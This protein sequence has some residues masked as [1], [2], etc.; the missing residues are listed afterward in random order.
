M[1][2]FIK[3]FADF[4]IL[5]IRTP[6]SRTKKDELSNEIMF[7]KKPLPL[8]ILIEKVKPKV[9]SKHEFEDRVRSM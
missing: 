6:V 9:T 3:T 1:P 4:G 8:G 7:A 5:T 2:S